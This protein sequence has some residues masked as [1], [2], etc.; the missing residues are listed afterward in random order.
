MATEHSL[1]AGKEKIRKM[2]SQ[3]QDDGSD[4]TI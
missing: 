2:A 1:E 4:K 3:G